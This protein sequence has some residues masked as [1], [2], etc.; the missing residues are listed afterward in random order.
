MLA[1]YTP[2]AVD[3]RAALPLPV[4][5]D[6]RLS[7][8][9]D[10]PFDVSLSPDKDPSGRAKFSGSIAYRRTGM[11]EIRRL[12]FDYYQTAGGARPT[13]IVNPISG[14]GYEFERFVARD[15]SRR[16]YQALVLFRPPGEEVDGLGEDF[17]ALEEELR[18]AVASRR[19]LVDWLQTLSEVDAGHIGLHG[20]SLG[21]MLT[22]LHAAADSR[23]VASVVL[24]AGGGFPELLCRSIEPEPRRLARANGVPSD[25]T[26]AQLAAFENLARPVL[27]TDPILLAPYIDPHSVLMVTTSRDLSVPSFL[28]ER[29]CGALGNPT[30]LSLPTGHYGA[31]IYVPLIQAAARSFLDAKLR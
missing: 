9:A 1:G 12:R 24:M 29:L 2:V 14:G 27:L 18:S 8:D 4:E 3:A 21:G 31:V 7:C 20:T 10:L 17:Q 5:V 30:T 22:V 16:G 25:A 6:A 26:E 13:V 19:R 15:L 23:I 11:A 28:Q